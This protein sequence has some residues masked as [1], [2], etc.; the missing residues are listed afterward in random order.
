MQS[1]CETL[2]GY[3]SNPM[4]CEPSMIL[5]TTNIHQFTRLW[6][7]RKTCVADL[8]AHGSRGGNWSFSCR[9]SQQH[10]CLLLLASCWDFKTVQYRRGRTLVSR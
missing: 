9:V 2:G 4:K 6:H 8:M 10:L 3:H 7:P 1:R 5:I